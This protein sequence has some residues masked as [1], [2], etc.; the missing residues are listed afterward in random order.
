MVALRDEPFCSVSL[1]FFVIDCS[2]NFSSLCFLTAL[3]MWSSAG[4]Y[5][6]QYAV[7]YIATSYTASKAHPST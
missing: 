5:F 3:R 4:L 1:L 7:V 2:A 6:R